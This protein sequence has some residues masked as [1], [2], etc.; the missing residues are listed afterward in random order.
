MKKETKKK[1]TKKEK[2]LMPWWINLIF[3]TYSKIYMLLKY[4]PKINRKVLK[5]QKRGCILIYNHSSNKDHYFIMSACNYRPVNFVLASYF[6]FNKVLGKILTWAK[7]ISKDQF[8]PDIAAI[9]KMKKVLDQN[10]IVAIAPAGQISMDGTP[11]YISP[12]IVKL[13]KM[14]KADVIGLKMTGVNLSLPKW[15]KYPRRTKINLEFVKVVT[16]EELET[17]KDNEIYERVVSSI[18]VDEYLNQQRLPQKIKGKHLAEGLEYF[19]VR[20]PKCGKRH[21]FITKDDLLTCTSCNNQIRVNKYGLLEKVEDDCKTFETIT[22]QYAWQKTEIGK[23][24]EQ[25]NFNMTCDVELI[26]NKF[27]PTEFESL[28]MGKL[29]LT[30]TEC[31]YEGTLKGEQFRKD[32]K[33]DQL[34]QLPFDP[35]SHF[36]IPNEDCIY[37]FKPIKKPSYVIDFVQVVDYINEKKQ[38]NF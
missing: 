5:A 6:Y 14:A 19:F 22:E 31:F 35:H 30:K 8:K 12:A 34:I 17:L 37:R 23:E 32:F 7:G 36:E 11:P 25:D 2:V 3:S 29:V 9:R 21:T 24:Y 20:C 33:Y 26:S 4:R 16:K 15:R 28:G 38:L 10:G 18:Y 13:I 27:S 1:K